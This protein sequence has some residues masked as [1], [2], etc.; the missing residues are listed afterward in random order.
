MGMVACE[1][2]TSIAK[3]L[4]VCIIDLGLVS[5][6]GKGIWIHALDFW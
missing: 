2:Q 1:E 4:V 3:D 6:R 5:R